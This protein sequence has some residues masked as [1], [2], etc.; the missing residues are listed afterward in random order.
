M[1]SR[2]IDMTGQRFGFLVAEAVAFYKNG[3]WWRMRCDCGN[4][5]VKRGTY[6]RYLPKIGTGEWVSCGCSWNVK[7]HGLFKGHSR[8][9]KIF[10]GMKKRCYTTTSGDFHN[11]GGRGIKIC[12]EWL[13][14]PGAFVAWSLSNGYTDSLSI[15]RQRVNGNYEPGNCRW[16]TKAQQAANT[17]HVRLIEFNGKTQPLSVWAREIGVERGT[18]IARFRHGWPVDQALTVPAFLGRNSR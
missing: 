3:A 17:R 4:D 10:Y 15:D 7:T 5:I 1:R 8:I 13:Q 11:Y 16:A 9:L 14:N 12:Q 18:L 2:T 6:L